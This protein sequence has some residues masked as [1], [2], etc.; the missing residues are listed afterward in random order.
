MRT[1]LPRNDEA[2]ALL[3]RTDQANRKLALFIHGFK[4]NYLTTWGT[5]PDLFE[6]EADKD[7]DFADWDF[8]F[9][10]YDT[11][12]VQTYLDISKLIITEW[13]KAATGQRPYNQPYEKLALF[14]HSL[15][16][17]GIRQLL[18][19]W[20]EQPD[21]MHGCIHSITLFGS[22][23][24]GSS[25]ASWFGWSGGPIGDAL[26]PKNPQLR[27]LKSWSASAYLRQQW[28]PI[29]LIL[30]LDD[31]VVGHEYDELIQWD[32]DEKPS[33]I[34]NFDHSTMVKPK[35]W[36]SAVVDYVGQGLR[37]R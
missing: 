24:N 12:A 7:E 18:C 1:L 17:L 25:L 13:N 32:G 23:L 6:K 33:I 19:A 34:T 9:L 10:G 8:L 20:S 27:M 2:W 3:R 36:Q 5:L 11:T 26:K 15:G 16:T 29:R 35:A 28:P 21:T 14:G 4:G 37:A 30:G 22:P 31:Q